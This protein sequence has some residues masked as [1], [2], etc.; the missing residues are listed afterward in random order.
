MFVCAV[1]VCVCASVYL[2]LHFGLLPTRALCRAA[3]AIVDLFA[4]WFSPA[5]FLSP[6]HCVL[7]FQLDPSTLFLLP[8]LLPL[9]LL[10]LL[11]LLVA[12]AEVA[13]SFKITLSR[14][15]SKRQEKASVE[16]GADAPSPSL[17]VYIPCIGCHTF[18]I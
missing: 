14:K 18:S 11:V 3:T 7:F 13:R 16:Q 15:L 2:G 4:N 10:S 6:F 9:S 1:F 17:L 5:Q 8:A 12:G